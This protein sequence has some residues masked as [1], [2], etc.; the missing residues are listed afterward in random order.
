M[1]YASGMSQRLETW[2]EGTEGVIPGTVNADKL[3]VIGPRFTPARNTSKSNAQTGSA[4]PRFTILGKKRVEWSVDAECNPSSMA[5]WLKYLFGTQEQQG[6][7][8]LFWT[9]YNLGTLPSFGAQDGHGGI[10]RFFQYLGMYAGSGQFTFER[11][12]A[13]TAS[14]SGLGRRAQTPTTTTV[15]NGTVNDRTTLKPFSYLRG[16][17]KKGGTKV[18]YIQSLSISVDRGLGWDSAIDETDE[19]AVI[20][21][22]VANITGNITALMTVDSVTDLYTG[23]LNA[24]SFEIEVFVPYGSGQ[25]LWVVLPNAL[26]H[27]VTITPNGTGLVTLVGSV[28]GQPG[29]TKGSARSKFFGS[30]ALATETLVVSVNGEADQTV[31]FG[32]GDDTPEEA[33]VAIN[34]ILT[35][36]TAR[37]ER[38]AGE[39]GAAIVI[40]SDTA[41]SGG[42]IQIKGASTADTILGFDN[43]THS[44]KTGVAIEPWL[45]NKVAA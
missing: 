28:E 1:A 11:E 24:D 20:F 35:G 30:E 23:A 32:A 9:R 16:R 36:G 31:T 39:T 22:E 14:F 21:S 25:G 27:S 17:V 15:V 4:E 34:A 12:G 29:D 13:M 18:G 38:M 37:L 7:S 42:S 5:P 43:V 19:A 10:S 8:S 6:S 2:P 45:A 33:I 26:I 40:E 3:P 41:G 44:G